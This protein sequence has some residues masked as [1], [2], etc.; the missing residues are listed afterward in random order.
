MRQG[1]TDRLGLVLVLLGQALGLQ[2]RK[3]PRVPFAVMADRDRAL[4]QMDH[5]DSVRMAALPV[6]DVVVVAAVSGRRGTCGHLRG[7]SL[8]A[9]RL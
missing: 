9:L 7:V 4:A 2:V 6:S 8:V 5:L 1:H 3:E